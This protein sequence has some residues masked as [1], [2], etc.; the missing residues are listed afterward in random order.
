MG[1]HL[2]LTTTLWSKHT[3]IIISIYKGKSWFSESLSK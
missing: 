3:I 1:I 2:I